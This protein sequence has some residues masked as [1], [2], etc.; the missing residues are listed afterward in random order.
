MAKNIIIAA[1]AAI[2]LLLTAC[3]KEGTGGN[4]QIMGSVKHHDLLIP[5]ATV[6]IKYGA[7]D[8]P[9]SDVSKYDASTTADLTD[10]HYHFEGLKRGDYFLYGVGYDSSISAP[11]VGGVHVKIK[12][13]DR[14]KTVEQ[15]VPVTE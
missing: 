12:F 3:S 10:A 11:V 9:G 13:G 14:K 4:A 8:F 5:G 2:A 1:M 7:K 6:Y 15:D